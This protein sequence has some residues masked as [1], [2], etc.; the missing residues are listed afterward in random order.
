M[1]P[2]EIKSTYLPLNIDENKYQ[3]VPTEA[4]NF[5]IR[6]RQHR[7]AARFMM[8]WHA[9]MELL[10]FRKGG[11]VI[12]C[13]GEEYKTEDGDLVIVNPNDLHRGDFRESGVHYFCIQIPPDMFLWPGIEQ[14]HILRTHISG[15]ASIRTMFDEIYA[16][17]WAKETGYK[18]ETL[19]RVFS[20]LAYLI[21]NYSAETMDEREFTARS[22]KLENINKLI[23]YV[24]LNYAESLT[25]QMA[26]SMTHLSEY[27]FCHLFKERMGISFTAYL[28]EIRIRKAVALLTTSRM[29]IT[30]ISAAVG[31]SD[32]NYFS[33]LFKRIIGV[34]PKHYR[35]R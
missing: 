18:F 16:A 14:R 30:E 20:L 31:F 6:L 24:E 32:V 28:N 1:M 26:A 27:Y 21:R 12:Y 23:D 10:F 17:Y 7:D 5:P 34:S 15:D 9:H 4:D 19:G 22:K 35:E 8:H 29:S 13:G 2:D 33:R 11:A 25:T 3:I